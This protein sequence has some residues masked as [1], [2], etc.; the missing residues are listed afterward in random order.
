MFRGMHELT[1]TE[2]PDKS[3]GM[4]YSLFHLSYFVPQPFPLQIGY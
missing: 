2:L 3:A 1:R 4:S